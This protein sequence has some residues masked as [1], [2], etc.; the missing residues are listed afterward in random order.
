[1]R[2]SIAFI[3]LFLLIVPILTL[4]LTYP[5]PTANLQWN[6]PHYR[7]PYFYIEW[8]IID[9]PPVPCSNTAGAYA[10]PGY[11]FYFYQICGKDSSLAVYPNIQRYDSESWSIL[12]TAHS[13]GG[14][15]NHSAAYITDKIVV[16]GGNTSPGNY[17][18]YT[19]VYN[20]SANTWV[21]S[22]PMPQAHMINTA[23]VSNGTNTCWLM[24]GEIGGT[25]TVLNTVY[26]WAPD[27]ISMQ[28]MAPMPA[29]R[30]N[31]AAAYFWNKI[32]VFGGASS[33]DVGTN[34][35]WLYDCLA[36]SW[37]VVPMLLAHARTGAAAVQ[38][39]Y[40]D[41]FIIGGQNGATYLSNVER[42]RP[43]DNTLTDVAPM[44]FATAGMAAGGE[45]YGITKVKD[46]EYSGDFYVSGGFNGTMV[47]QANRASVANGAVETSSLGNIKALFR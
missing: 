46:Q 47:T 10:T 38:A 33:G 25:G 45:C 20:T 44:L 12:P 35:I 3:L 11:N 6:K 22:T 15:Y 8:T 14:V 21:Q 19:T 32:Y 34:S 40:T 24:G 30:K 2:P 39:L 37:S 27:D 31:V 18:D 26:K 43:E 1:M 16:S 23:M 29:P 41:I 5:D 36:N 17:Y 9:S 4:A 13:G 42:Y 7:F 28:T